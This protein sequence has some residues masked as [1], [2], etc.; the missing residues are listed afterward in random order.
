MSPDTM[1]LAMFWVGAL[2]V[3]T[4]ILVV[5]VVI[6]TTWYLRKKRKTGAA[7]SLH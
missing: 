6:G 2:F 1:S 7:P 3:F 4:P 5:A